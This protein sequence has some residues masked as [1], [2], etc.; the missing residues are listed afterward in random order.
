MLDSRAFV[1]FRLGQ[2]D[3]AVADDNAALGIA[4]KAASTL[5]VRGLAKRRLGNAAGGDADLAAAKA[6][7]PKVADAYARLGVTP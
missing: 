1:Y 3:K 4:P 2:F 5:Y 7:Y 6:I